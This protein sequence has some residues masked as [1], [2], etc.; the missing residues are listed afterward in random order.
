M[1]TVLITGVAG[2]L[3]SNLAD[4][5]ISKKIKVI[6]VDDLS[7]G[8]KE[9]VNP[10]VKLNILNLTKDVESLNNIFNSNKI[11]YYVLLVS[12]FKDSADPH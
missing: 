8:Y 7:G 3:G 6:G 1:N 10:E 2:L 12:E 5:L 4:Y 9:N 11:D